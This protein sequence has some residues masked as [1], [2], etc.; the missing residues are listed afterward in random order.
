MAN[1][2]FVPRHYLRQ[3]TIGGSELITVAQISPLKFLG[4]KGIGGESCERDYYENDAGI[5]KTLQVSENDIAPVLAKINQAGNFSGPE[6][7]ALQMLAVILNLR[8]R[9]SIERTKLLPMKIVRSLMEHKIKRGELPPAP[10]NVS[11]DD[12]ID[13]KGTASLTF[14]EIIPCFLNMS[15]LTPK[16]LKAEAGSF[17]ITSDNPVVLL[18]QF[19]SETIPGSNCAGYGQTGFQLLMPISP[20]YCLI[21]FDPKVY[22]IGNRHHKTVEI[23]KRDVG[24]VN[25]FQVQS[26]ENRLYYHHLALGSQMMNLISKYGHLRKPLDSHVEVLPGRHPEEEI[27]V[28][29]NFA[30]S[31]PEVWHFCKYRRHVAAKPGTERYEG[32]YD[33]IKL[34]LQDIGK[35]PAT[36]EKIFDRINRLFSYQNS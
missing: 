34:L 26:A 12:V 4:Y 10:G 16:L 19:C 11:L 29:K 3:F 24:I 6:I 2:H 5:E 17:F 15:T 18:N 20:L 9:H 30:V 36:G 13:I 14:G 21:A 8:T 31:L 28:S 27:F 23:S 1:D 32:M 35:N 33:S 7:V 22:K 25:S